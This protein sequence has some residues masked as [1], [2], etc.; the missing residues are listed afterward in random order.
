M[1]SGDVLLA[2]Y[3]EGH[4]LLAGGSDYWFV[5]LPAT[6]HFVNQ[7]PLTVKLDTLNELVEADKTNNQ[8]TVSIPV[9]YG[10][11]VDLLSNKATYL[12]SETAVF[13]A[14]VTASN[15]PGVALGAADGVTATLTICD[16]LG[17]TAA[18]VPMTFDARQGL[19]DCTFD[20]SALADG[21]YTAEVIAAGPL[22]TRTSSLSFQVAS[23][24]AVT[25]AAD[26]SSY[27]RGESVALSGIAQRLDGSN[28]VNQQITLQLQN[29]GTV[30]T[31][32]A[33]TDST[34]HFTYAFQPVAGEGGDYVVAASATCIGLVRTAQTSFDIQG[35]LV[36]LPAAAAMVLKGDVSQ[37]TIRL[38]N[39]GSIEQ[40]GVT[41]ELVDLNPGDAVD[42]IVD[43]ASVPTTIDPGGGMAGHDHV[44]GRRFDAATAAAFTV[45]IRSDQMGCR[46]HRAENHQRS[47]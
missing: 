27:Q 7:W 40:T 21:Q 11:I 15:A 41:V 2:S 14:L 38:Q 44:S 4:Y 26:K 31:F 1:W 12:P 19:L 39:V 45:V 32:Q 35:I 34:G 5:N 37:Y 46:R 6:G 25:L 47:G 30:R 3:R 36:S 24:F 42:A 16:A 22:G 23:D 43:P 33:T 9:Q 13:S 28:L 29:A 8:K 18:S 20:V 17:V 10:Y